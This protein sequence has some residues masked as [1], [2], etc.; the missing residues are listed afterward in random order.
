MDEKVF[1][2]AAHALIGIGKERGLRV[3]ERGVFIVWQQT[4]QLAINVGRRGMVAILAIALPQSV[5]LI[6]ISAIHARLQALAVGVHAGFAH[7]LR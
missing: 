1:H 5:E 3:A 4:A 6:G 7:R 2:F